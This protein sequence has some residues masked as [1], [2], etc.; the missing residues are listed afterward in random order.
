[1]N[2]NDLSL[3]AEID[4]ILQKSFLDIRKRIVTVV[5]K[6]N[7]K[8]KKTVAEPPV[9]QRLPPPSSS[10]HGSSRKP[11]KDRDRKV[12]YRKEEEHFSSRSVSDDSDD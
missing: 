11:E 4:R 7:K 9:K 3:E 2:N 6:H 10:T 5:A 8:V 12:R 1:M